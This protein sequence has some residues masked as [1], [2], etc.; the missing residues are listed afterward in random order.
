MEDYRWVIGSKEY[1]IQE[2]FGIL[3]ERLDQEEREANRC[4]L[5][6]YINGEYQPS[7][8]ENRVYQQAITLYN[9][10]VRRINRKNA[11]SPFNNLLESMDAESIDNVLRVIRI[12]EEEIY[13]KWF[14]M[15]RNRK[16]NPNYKFRLERY[17][18]SRGAYW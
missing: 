9:Q 5:Y 15:G 14:E 12:Q 6:D 16:S 3:N 10:T 8:Y 4:S 17:P 2:A 1:T 7:A 13:H 18:D 11:T